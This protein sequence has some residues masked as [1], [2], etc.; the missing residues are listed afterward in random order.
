MSKTAAEYELVVLQNA[1]S[2]DDL[3][4]LNKEHR[5]SS[6]NM[7]IE[8]LL[9]L[10]RRNVTG[11][12]NTMANE[13]LTVDGKSM[14]LTINNTRETKRQKELKKSGSKGFFCGF[15]AATKFLK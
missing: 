3:K 15:C 4:C 12:K 1:T 9:S 8:S 13:G 14:S 7:V 11:G 6:S 10:K 5:R 2:V